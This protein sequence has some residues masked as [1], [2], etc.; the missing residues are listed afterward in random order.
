MIVWLQ[1]I[2]L[3]G[4][5]HL[6]RRKAFKVRRY[7]RRPHRNRTYVDR[8]GP[9]GFGHLT[10]GI[11]HRHPVTLYDLPNIAVGDVLVSYMFNLLIIALLDFKS[12]TAPI[13]SQ[14]HQGQV[15]SAAF[16]VLL[17]GPV[18][19]SIA[20]SAKIPAL[21]WFSASSGIFIVVYASAIRIV[22]LYEKKRIAELVESLLL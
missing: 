21:G 16:G 18:S 19:T 8:R 20:A 1:F 4:G 10:T 13:A 12:G 5:H 3:L 6:C 17:L 2:A 9:A 7:L 14:A 15:L 22:S 11:D